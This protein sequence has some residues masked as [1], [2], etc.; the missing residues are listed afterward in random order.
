MRNWLKCVGTTRGRSQSGTPFEALESRTLLADG[1]APINNIDFVWRG[2]EMEVRQHSWIMTFEQALGRDAARLEAETVASSMGLAVDRLDIS[3]RG[4]FAIVRTQT[5]ITE[6]AVDAARSRFGQLMQIE[7][8]MIYYS[9]LVPNDARYGEQWMMNNVGQIEFD[10]DTG[11]FEPG[12]IGADMDAERGWN[13]STGSSRVVIAVIDTGVEVDHPDLAA[14]IY[15]NPGEIANNGIDDDRNGFIDDVNGWDFGSANPDNDPTDPLVAG[16][17][18]AV[19]GTIGAVGNNGIGVAGV[20]WNIK[21]LPMKI[22]DDAGELSNSAI[23]QSL[24]YVTMMRID[25][26]VNIVATNNSYGSLRPEDFEFGNDAQRIAIQD[27]TDAG[28]LFVAAAGNDSLDNDSAQRAYP[29]SYLNPDIIAVAAT[30]HRD[31][32]A[33]F[34]NYGATTVDVGAPGEQVLTTEVGGGYARIDGTSFASPYTAGVVGMI[35]AVNPFLGPQQIKAI[36][37]NS[38]DVL[39]Q[40]QG[41]VL[42]GGRVNLFRA[43]LNASFEGPLVTAISPGPQTSPVQTVRV[44]FSKDIDPAFFNISGIELRRT[45]ADARFDAN[46]I[47]LNLADTNVATVTLTA[48]ELVINLTAPLD[49]DLFRLTLNASNFRDTD[50]RHLNGNVSGGNNEVYTFNVVAFRGP[51]EPNDSISQAT[52]VVFTGGIANYSELVIGDGLFEP[53][54]VDMFRVFATG[55]SLITIEITARGLGVPSTLDSFVRLFDS[56]G[57]QLVAND[58]FNGLDSKIQFFVAAA[59]E[60]YVGVSAYPNRTYNPSI[61]GSGQGSPSL[62][63]Y[64]LFFQIQSNA[65]DNASR[66]NET[67]LDIPSSGVITSTIT[68]TDGRSIADLDVRINIAHTFVGDLRIRLS[69][70]GG[71]TVTLVNRRGGAG[72]NFNNTRFDDAAPVAITAG[73]PPYNGSFRPETQL[74]TYNGTTGAGT[75]TLTIEDLRAG[76]TGM[77]LSWG[78]DLVLTNDVFGPFE[79]N[80]TNLIATTTDIDSSGSRT[81][82]AAIGDGAFGLLDV[83]MF[84]FT[85]G[86]GTTISALA[87]PTGTSSNLD[88]IL[89]LFDVNGNEVAADKRRGSTSASLTYVVGAAGIYYIGVS[90]GNTTSDSSLGNDNYQ[91]GVGGS[92]TATDAT[93]NYSLLLNV[94]GGISEG[95]VLLDGSTLDL[96]VAANGA[97]GFSTTPPSGASPTGLVFNGVDFLLQNGG[98]DSYFGASVDGFAAFNAGDN[99]QTD[100]AVSLA[101]E[102]DFGNRRVTATGDFRNLGVR[103]VLSFSADGRAIAVDVTLTNRSINVINNLAWM[104]GFNPDQGYDGATQGS[105]ATRN[106][107]RTAS[108]KLGTAADPASGRTIG[109]GAASTATNAVVSFESRGTVRDPFTI[110]NSIN[111]PDGGGDAGAVDDLDLAVAFNLGTLGPSQSTTFRYFI[112]ADT[113]AAAVVNAYGAMNGGTGEGHLAADAKNPADDGEGFS[114]LPYRVYYPEGYANSRANTFLPLING[115]AEGIRVQ[116]IARYERVFING[117][118]TL[119][120]PD[121]LYDSAADASSG[122]FVGTRRG[123]ITITRPDL[124]TAGTGQRVQSEVIV[125]QSQTRR[126][127]VRKDVPF[128][129][130][131]RSSAP[132]GAILSHYDFG[133]ATGDSFTSTLNTTWLLGEGNK[134]SGIND[135]VTFYNP[136]DTSIKVTLTAYPASGGSPVQVLRT[137]LPKRRGGWSIS[138]IPQI[139]DGGVSFR[140]DAEAPIVAALTH[141]DTANARGFGTLAQPGSGSM[142]GATGEGAFGVGAGSE[143]ISVINPGTTSSTVVFTFAF[144]T[145]SS[146]RHTINVPAGRRASF[147]VSSLGGFPTGQAYAVS[148]TSSQPV[149]V[150]IASNT[151]GEEGGSSLAAQAS[152]QWL[153]AEGFRP[154]GAPGSTSA[155]TEFLRLYNPGAEATTIEIVINYTNGDSEV[156]RRNLPARAVFDLNIHDLVTGSKASAD[157]Y[158]GLKVQ[159]SRP[160]VAFAGHYDSFLRGGFGTLGTPLGTTGAAS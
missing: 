22:G 146:F 136:G 97:L 83:D 84:R 139:P 112:F 56:G 52:P 99:A 57:A 151:L 18:T 38:V 76:D 58:N 150:N 120:A 68:L 11:R 79:V 60:Y 135:F 73:S 39:P 3:A 141:F 53:V 105:R 20:A 51:L 145:G 25:F 131:V 4:R 47:I 12:V 101:H 31:L 28:I 110:I 72:D 108:P 26:G 82:N 156:F 128:A 54:D 6:G 123:G 44:G 42:T 86:S 140:L 75:W 5:P 109:I 9:Q 88:L 144:T 61:E 124:Y 10:P 77:L 43:L 89:R 27:S 66:D 17:G 30:N 14:N 80:D 7:P 113:S 16:H 78:L 121:L 114:S 132:V 153:F 158:Y 70:P 92:G 103:R 148:Y 40:L 50:G 93:G 100:I 2:I 35:A 19:A 49:R 74:A 129:L 1:S 115:N 122:Q 154:A 85:A 81:F 96:G 13:I 152:T 46:D 98:V 102:S 24:D 67:D 147:D 94:S 138:E 41:R 116:V 142:S 55:P 23:V 64:S 63:G 21:M 111:D 29:A 95:T 130:E 160:I 91:P 107:I 126:D 33:G 159:A 133:I 87:Q 119:Y 117:V 15:K 137:V 143:K 157:A 69:G 8:D 134:G 118:E 34:S 149:G 48:R 36:L 59:G 155:V 37:L 104:E 90:G 106:S 62:G 71:Q 45:N 32:L 65:S 125:Q 127:G